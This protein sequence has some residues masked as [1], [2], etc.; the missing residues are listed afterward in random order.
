MRAI[1]VDRPGGP[2]VLHLAEAP[3]PVPAPGEVLLRVRGSAVNR[4]DILQRLGFYP[5]PPGASSIL[6][7]EASGVVE[8]VTPG[9]DTWRVGDQACALLSGGGYAELVAVPAGQLMPVPEGLDLLT[10][11]AVPEVF[12][13]AHDNLVT[14]GGL[15]SGETVLVQGGCGGV[16]TAAIQLARRA[17]A[18]VLTTAGSD[19]RLERC[20]ELGATGLINHRTGDVVARVRE[21]TGGRGADV[22]LDVMGASHLSANLECLAEDGRLVVIGLQGGARAELDL[23]AMLRRRQTLIATTLR[24]RPAA[25]KAAIVARAVADVLPGFADGTLRA[26]IDAVFPLADAA[27]AHRRMESGGHVG[28]LLLDVADVG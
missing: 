1:V 7:L 6:G 19:E 16:G 14:R 26:V 18:T 17:G 8:A 23:G 12:L 21:L 11:A 24:S 13:T 3:D 25:Q 27:A 9:V 20:R 4:A 2:E 28:K 22:I 15:R 5:P 10:A